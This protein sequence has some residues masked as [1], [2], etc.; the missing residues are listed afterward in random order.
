MTLDIDLSP[1]A[2]KRLRKRAEASGLELATFVQKLVEDEATKPTLDEILS[3]VREDF[4]RTGMSE[5]EILQFGS[6][7][8]RKVREE[9]QAKRR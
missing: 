2:E 6:D 1:E 4:A 9:S 3:P 8:V 5:D 7:L